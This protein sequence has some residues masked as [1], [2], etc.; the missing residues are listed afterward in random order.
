MG[1]SLGDEIDYPVVVIRWPPAERAPGNGE[2]SGHFDHNGRI[3]C[4]VYQPDA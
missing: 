3:N 1:P 2:G 4:K